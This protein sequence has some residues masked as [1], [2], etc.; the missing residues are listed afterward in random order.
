MTASDKAFTGS[1]PQIYDQ[2]MVPLIFEPYAQDLAQRITARQPRDVL[3][4]AAGTGVVTRALHAH[5]PPD[6]GIT[7][8]DLNA[9]MLMQAKTHLADA[10]R[11]RWQQ[12]D[13]LAVPFADASFDAVACQFGVMFFPDR[14]KGYAEAR[15]V[16]KPGGRFIFNVWDRIEDN[17]FPLVVHETLQQL[18]P[19]DPPQFF[20]RTPHGYYDTERIKTDLTDAG[21][22][23]IVIETVTHRSHA[24]SPHEPAMA[25][26]QG[27]PMRGEIEA[28]GTPGLAAVTQAVADALGRRFGTGPIE[29]RIQ[30]L[31][32]SA[33]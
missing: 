25:F 28:R 12:A 18:F 13:A 31:V 4:T 9:P 23:D 2:F 22:T 14:I 3:E 7:A 24:A 11:I 10:A 29:G 26:C 30:A 6:V 16:L 20:T 17:A 33:T 32:I 5:L 15:R 1:I 19:D 8:T 21:F 27:T